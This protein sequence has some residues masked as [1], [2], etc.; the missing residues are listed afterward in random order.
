MTL[1]VHPDSNLPMRSLD[2]H[3]AEAPLLP[4]R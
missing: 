3:G 2:E 4:R 1:C